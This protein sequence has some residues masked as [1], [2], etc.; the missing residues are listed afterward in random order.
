MCKDFQ[1]KVQKGF[2]RVFEA[3]AKLVTK[4]AIIVFLFSVLVFIGLSLGMSKAKEF[5]DDNNIWT[6]EGNPSLKNKEKAEVLFPQE[7]K[8]HY[9]NVIFEAKGDNVL[10][11]GALQ[12]MRTFEE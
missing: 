4:R 7:E 8:Y 10:T 5:D 6:P 11:F 9:I 3:W 12:E 1:D 2:E